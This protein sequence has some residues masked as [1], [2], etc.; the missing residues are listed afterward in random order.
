MN[1]RNSY[2]TSHALR[3][4]LWA[5]LLSSGAMQLTVTVDAI[6]MGHF[7]GSN[8]LSAI[9]LVMPLT[10]VI[11]ALSTLIG[12]GPAIMASKAIGNREYTKVNM[13]FSSAIFQAVF[14]GGCIG[15]GCW[16]FSSEIAS[17]LC[18]NHYL[19]P[20]LTDYLQVLPWCFGLTILVFSLVSLIEADGHPHFATK[21]LLIGALCH[22]GFEVLCVGYW[23]MGIKG[24]AYAMV[25]NNL[26]V[27]L[28]IAWGMHRYG[29]SYRWQFPRKNIANVTMAG[30]KEGM[31]MMM[32]DLLYSLMLFLL[33]AMVGAHLGELPLLH[34]A[35][36]VQLLMFVLVVVDCAE[37]AVLS[38]GGML[39]GE[40]D[41][42]GF[43]MLVRQLVILM[44]G[45]VL[46]VVLVVCCCPNCVAGLFGD[47]ADMSAEWSSNVRIFSLMLVPHAL[48]VFMRSFFQ[49]LDRRCLGVLFSFLQV[50]LTV[51]GFWTLSH[52]APSVV[53]WSFPLSAFLLLAV[54]AVFI[55]QLWRK[56]SNP[57][58][59]TGGYDTN[60]EVL[61]LSVAYDKKPVL[62][63]LVQVS[64][65]LERRSVNVASIMVVNICC[66]ELMLNIV[67]HQSHNHRSY[68]D[69]H[70]VVVGGKVCMV[71]K[72]AGRP[73]NP[74]RP[75]R[76][77]N[78]EDNDVSLGLALV[79]NV[80]STLSHKY[81]YGQNVV[82]AEFVN[83]K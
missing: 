14:I 56:R 47:G 34:W 1:V 58:L 63:A 67:R 3:N 35:I 15:V 5:S 52:W 39:I 30:L 7:V 48:S 28:F 37:G 74:V 38:I 59:A 41:G 68:M 76:F 20:Y 12:V 19:L 32:N 66:E 40:K 42:Y 51:A 50:L 45:L 22:V 77:I 11:S 55:A 44:V 70:I 79:N 62:D 64:D 53:W 9:N 21:A 4:Y 46:V 10:M 24:A 54:Q 36:C 25:V 83:D 57:L 2:L 65:F 49:V 31:P 78:L 26:L 13:V 18:K 61:E 75:S 23:D 82:F 6:I 60:R 29:V 17:L 69:L 71:L 33:N 72:D 80:C 81:M 73:F 43:Y 16:R 8:A 27:V